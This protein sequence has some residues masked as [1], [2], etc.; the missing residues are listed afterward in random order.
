MCSLIP[1][2]QMPWCLS[3]PGQ[4]QVWYWL[5]RSNAFLH[6]M[7]RDFSNE[8]RS[9]LGERLT[10]TFQFADSLFIASERGGFLHKWPVM[11]KMFR[12]RHQDHRYDKKYVF[13]IAMSQSKMTLC[14]FISSPLCIK[15]C[16]ILVTFLLLCPSI[17]TLQAFSKIL[18][19]CIVNYFQYF[20]LVCLV[21]WILWIQ[22]ENQIGVSSKRY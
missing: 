19:S 9:I 20:I 16:R 11:W 13:K 4:Q 15:F 8:V 5:C 14:V 2:L 7:K 21:K 22:K 3:S 17:N 10:H 6:C 12:W 18:L 1:W